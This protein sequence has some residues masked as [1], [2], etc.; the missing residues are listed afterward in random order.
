M[1][2]KSKVV[3][4]T[5]ASRGIGFATVKKFA[6]NGWHVAAFYNQTTRS[7]IKGVSWYQLDISNY[8]SIKKSFEIAF[9]DLSRVDCFVNCAGIFGYKDLIGYEE[10]LMD[11]VIAVNEKGTYLSTKEIIGKMKE[12]SIIYISS[13]AAQIGSSDPIY[14]GTK[15]AIFGFTKAM[16]K[17][18]APKIRVNCISPSATNTDMMKN[19]K[20]ERV[21]QLKNMTLLKRLAEPEDIANSIYFLASKEAKHIT[22]TCLDVNGGYVLR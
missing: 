14:A 21:E 3:F 4:I 18:L 20:P 10:D 19:Y 11:K 9:K 22:G 1:T 5:G 16:A 12:G 13:T 6:T 2:P 7:R 8:S 15:S 17:A